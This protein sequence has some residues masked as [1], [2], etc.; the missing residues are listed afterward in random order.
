LFL[1][2][3]F[4]LSF[5]IYFCFDVLLS[6]LLD[7]FYVVIKTSCPLDAIIGRDDKP[8]PILGMRRGGVLHVCSGGVTSGIRHRLRFVFEVVIIFS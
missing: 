7:D 6:L 1:R 3:L 2:L 4:C 8:G 5:D